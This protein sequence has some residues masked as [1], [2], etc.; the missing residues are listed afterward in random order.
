M[1]PSSLLSLLLVELI[2]TPRIQRFHVLRLLFFDFYTEGVQVTLGKVTNT[3][4][5]VREHKSRT[6]RHY[7]TLTRFIMRRTRS[8]CERE[9]A[10]LVDVWGLLGGVAGTA[11]TDLGT[12]REE[13]GD[14]CLSSPFPPFTTPNAA[15]ILVRS[16]VRCQSMS[17][18]SQYIVWDT[19][20]VP[21]VNTPPDD[22][23]L[24]PP[25]DGSEVER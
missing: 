9:E 2:Q 16:R 1:P 17:R 5:I 18:P 8:A 10:L 7:F 6:A 3:V 21:G 19:L 24:T 14:G 13:D 12:V 15:A 11:F 23:T 22:R 20:A 4:H 25:G